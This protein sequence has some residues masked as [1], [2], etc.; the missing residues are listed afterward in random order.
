MEALLIEAMANLEEEKTLFLV[1]EQ[2]KAGRTAMEIV[3][4]CRK[5]VGIVGKCTVKVPTFY[6]I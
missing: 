2:L 1:K 6:P 3:E 5:G 4:S